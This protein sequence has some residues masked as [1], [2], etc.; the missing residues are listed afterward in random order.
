M[1]ST[2]LSMT[3]L[4]SPLEGYF[5]P[6]RFRVRM[7]FKSVDDLSVINMVRSGMGIAILPGLVLKENAKDVC[8]LRLETPL[9]R[10]LGFAYRKSGPANPALGCFLAFIESE[11]DRFLRNL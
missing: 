3:K 2:A 7:D 10:R 1:Y 6:S 5:E 9:V 8:V 4:F 11:K